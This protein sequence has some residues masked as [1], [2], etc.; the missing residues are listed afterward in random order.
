MQKYFKMARFGK[1]PVKIPESVKVEVSDSMLR[2]SGPKGNL[3]KKVPAELSLEKGADSLVVE[4]KT[5]SKE[6]L[7]LQGTMRAHIA[8]MVKGATEGWAKTLEL[9]GAGFKAD[10]QGREIVLTL[11]YSHP[12]KISAPEGV[13]FK[14]EKNL[15]TVS[16]ADIE[17]VSQT[18][19]KI[20]AAREPDPYKGKGIKYQ[21]EVLRKKPGKAAV[22]IGGGVQA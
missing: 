13:E 20:R 18:A 9:V 5:A 1:L 17:K 3:E 2:I 16:G 21:D 12:V 19:A 22:K 14:V 10:V 6:A 15:V 4:I 8:N 11:G 7:A